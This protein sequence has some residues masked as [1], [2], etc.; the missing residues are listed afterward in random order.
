MQFNRQPEAIALTH[1]PKYLYPFFNVFELEYNR[2]SDLEEYKVL[3]GEIDEFNRELKAWKD[4]DVEVR[5][6]FT[7]YHLYENLFSRMKVAMV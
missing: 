7:S 4:H 3:A 5:N 1:K 6:L 2:L